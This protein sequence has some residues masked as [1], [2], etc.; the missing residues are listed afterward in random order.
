M[1]KAANIRNGWR[2]TIQKDNKIYIN[3]AEIN[4]KY[5]SLN[6]FIKDNI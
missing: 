3:P 5:K 6:N 2:K 1:S 4:K